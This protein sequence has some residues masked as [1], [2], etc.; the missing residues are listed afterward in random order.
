MEL[1]LGGHLAFYDLERR[2]IRTVRLEGETPLIDV[3]LQLRIPAAEVGL[4]AVNREIVRLDEARVIDSDRVDLYPPMDGGGLR[5]FRT[6]RTMKSTF[7]GRSPSRR[8]K[9]G[10]HSVPNGT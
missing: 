5:S 3:L 2:P 1:H 7:C 8:M 9:Y 6:L 10:Y 4:A